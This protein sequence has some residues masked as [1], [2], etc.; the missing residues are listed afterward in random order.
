LLWAALRLDAV[1]NVEAV[2]RI[3]PR[4]Q[5]TCLQQLARSMG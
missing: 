2:H 3:E 1:L 5:T 4:A